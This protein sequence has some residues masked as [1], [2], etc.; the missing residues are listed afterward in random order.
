M[1][2]RLR[3][4]ST[5]FADP[6]TGLKIVRDQTVQISGRQGRLTARAIAQGRLLFVKAGAEAENGNGESLIADPAVPSPGSGAVETVGRVQTR[7]RSNLESI[8][9]A[10]GSEDAYAKRRNWGEKWLD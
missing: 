7:P 10:T 6:E 8:A 2:V 9:G 4:Q 1:K 3:D 5:G